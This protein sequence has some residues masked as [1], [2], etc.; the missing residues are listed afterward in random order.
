[1]SDLGT[2]D[3]VD[4]PKVLCYPSVIALKIYPRSHGEPMRRV[5]VVLIVLL[6]IPAVSVAGEP[7]SDADGDA[8]LQQRI[9]E[10]EAQVEELEGRSDDQSRRSGMPMQ[11]AF[12]STAGASTAA[13][14]FLSMFSQS[15]VPAALGVGSGIAT[16]SLTAVGIE[17]DSWEVAGSG[18][19]L[20][21]ASIAGMVASFVLADSP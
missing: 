3:D 10:L 16:G 17:L 8:E 2:P 15:A 6:S 19:V 21:V 9:A 13:G 12:W 14:V 1:M 20:T 7:D 18:I 11:M 4:G 5:V